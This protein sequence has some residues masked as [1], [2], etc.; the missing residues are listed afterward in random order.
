MGEVS[1]CDSIDTAPYRLIKKIGQGAYGTVYFAKG[2]EGDVALKICRRPADGKDDNYQR[3]RRGWAVYKKIPPHPGL[4]RIFSFAED[5]QGAF[6]Y[7]TMELAD[8]EE[9]D[10]ES[11]GPRQFDSETYRAKTLEDVLSAEVALS[12]SASIRLGVHLTEAV[13]HL[14]K[15]HLVHRDIKPGNVLIIK[16]KAVLADI[17]LMADTREASSIVGTPGYVPPENHGLPQGDVYSL[18]MTLFQASTGRTVEERDFPPRTEA[19][20][21]APFF[22]RWMMIVRKATSPVIGKRY[23][24]AKALLHDLRKL[25]RQVTLVASRK[26]RTIAA[27]VVAAFFFWS[28]WNFPIFRAWITNDACFRYHVPLP[29]PYRILTPFL[30]PWY[31]PCTPGCGSVF[32]LGDDVSR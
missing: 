10:D 19:D 13:V 20:V 23:N 31:D 26:I 2:P 29:W 8:E 9:E 16:G 18:G 28:A 5:P 1:Q 27:V 22:W 21:D 12:L 25:D 11:S 3:E 32:H 17:G 15:H 6:F 24:S 7:Y 14:Q 4:I 30:A